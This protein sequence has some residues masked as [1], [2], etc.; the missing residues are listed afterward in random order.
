M[1]GGYYFW[2]TQLSL[3]DAWVQDGATGAWARRG[4]PQGAPPRAAIQDCYTRSL[5]TAYDT[6]LQTCL[7]KLCA[8][9][10]VCINTVMDVFGVLRGKENAE[11][12]AA[13]ERNAV[14]TEEPS[15]ISPTST[16]DFAPSPSTAS[17]SAS[18]SEGGESASAPTTTP[19]S[20]VLS[21]ESANGTPERSIS[22]AAT[23]HIRVTQPAS[24][25]LLTSPFTIIGEAHTSVTA[26]VVRV[27]G[28]DGQ[29]LIEEK[30]IPRAAAVD[31]WRPF[32]LTLAYIFS[33]TKSGTIEVVPEGGGDPQSVVVPVEF[34]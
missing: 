19:A 11:P 26:L 31:D 32:K 7:V 10:P 21:Q 24:Q 29:V 23:T 33:R 20:H 28:G 8:S 13:P 17:D 9:E 18:E 22:V 14:S 2:R 16:I 1:G 15:L 6:A 3:S 27:R 12:P 34:K 4:S 30:I 25:S 5:R